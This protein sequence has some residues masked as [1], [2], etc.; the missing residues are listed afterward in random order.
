M[1]VIIVS[2][3]PHYHNFHF[4][5]IFTG[6]SVV[7]SSLLHLLLLHLLSAPF[8]T[9]TLTEGVEILPAVTDA[10]YA[11]LQGNEEAENE[12]RTCISS[13]IASALLQAKI[14]REKIDGFKDRYVSTCRRGMEEEEAR[15]R[16]FKGCL[17]KF[18][19]HAILFYTRD[20]LYSFIR[21]CIQMK[22]SYTVFYCVYDNVVQ[23][24]VYASLLFR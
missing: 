18:H 21:D 20:I 17:V 2:F 8:S 3:V 12:V 6:S 11:E 13:N 1:H 22:R 14:T 10:S 9:A 5:L 24:S 15:Q 16:N 19:R 23:I 7:I 4:C